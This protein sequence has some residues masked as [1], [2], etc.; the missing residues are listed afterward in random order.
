M[1][2]TKTRQTELDLLKICAFLCVVSLH[3]TVKVWFDAPIES[4]QW[5]VA[6]AFRG[7]WAV[8]VFV[9]ISGRFLLD[10]AKN[11]S[12][13]KLK[14]YMGRVVVAFAVWS[15]FYE[16]YR[17]LVLYPIGD[18]GAIDWKWEAVEFMTGEYH[19]WYLPML[20]GLYLAVPFLRKI[21][22]DKGLMRRYLLLFFVM[23][24]ISTYGVHLPKVGVLIRPVMDN[25]YFRFAM[26]YTGYFVLGYYLS[27][28]EVSRKKER[29]IY[30]LGLLCLIMTPVAN[31]IY[32]LRTGERT[33]FF[34]ENLTPNVILAAAAIYIFFSKRI[35]CVKFSIPVRNAISKFAGLGFGAY[36]VH[37]IFI[38]L[39]DDFIGID[40][41][42][43][44]PLLWV[45]VL[46]VLISAISLLCAAMLQKIP[47]IGKLIA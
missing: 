14:G 23:E 19:L 47:R 43:G 17:L 28:E 29:W 40:F 6:N 27:I 15:A 45:P 1:I 41:L 42:S 20:A 37:V 32:A 44:N 18:L 39:I 35:S 30:A 7:T 31:S 13:P 36:L 26:G 4:W 8:P 38:E 46:T 2:D 22:Q 11:V 21:C 5:Q 34:S 12:S 24:A 25:M 9:M 16:V 10:P 33:E 3:V